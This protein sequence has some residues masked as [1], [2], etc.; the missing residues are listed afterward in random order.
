MGSTVLHSSGGIAYDAAP[1]TKQRDAR[2]PDMALRCGGG[3]VNMMPPT[4]RA[5]TAAVGADACVTSR[6]VGLSFEAASRQNMPP[7]DSAM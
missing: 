1:D 5:S 7:R 3:N 2:T 6:C 4:G